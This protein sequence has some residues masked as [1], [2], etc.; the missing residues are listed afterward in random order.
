MAFEPDI[1]ITTPDGITLVVEAKTALRD[2]ERTEE[3]LK[4]YMIGMQCPVGLLIT[5]ERMWLYRDFYTARSPVSVKR[6]GEFNARPMW[7]QPPPS[8]G[9]AFEVF[10]QQWLEDLAKQPTGE[11]PEELRDALR[12]YVL[13]AVV[14]GEVRAAHP[15][16]RLRK[17]RGTGRARTPF[18]LT[19]RNMCRTSS[20]KLI[21]Y[22]RT[23]RR[24][25]IRFRRLR[26]CSIGRGAA[27]SQSI[28]PTSA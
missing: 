23:L 19:E 12:E 17:T 7:R 26:S 13:P 14:G 10:V 15:Q 28:Y 21:G 5:P 9:E 8:Q 20:W 24:R 4:Q 2:L 1:L 25:I 6:V 3:D 27:S 18:G 16:L 11:F 22:L